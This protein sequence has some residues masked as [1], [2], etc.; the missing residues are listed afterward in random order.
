[1][2]AHHGRTPAV[3][4]RFFDRIEPVHAVT[5][6][7]PEARA[8][9]D[10]LG[11]RGF[12][13]GYFAARSAPLGVVP[14][15]VVTAAFYNFAPQRVAKALPT[16]WTVAPPA[17]ALEA[18]LDAAVAALLRAGVTDEDASAAAE[19]AAAAATHAEVGGRV[20]FAAN[21]ALEWPDRPVARLWHAATLLREH[22][23][24]GHV[25]VLLAEGVSGRE[26][27]VLHAAAGRV[28]AAMIQRSRDYDDDEWQRHVAALAE[29]GLLTADGT[30]TDAGH[31]LKEHLEGRTDASALTA[32]DVLSDDEL[33]QLFRALTPLTRTVIAAG[34]IPAGTPMG[35]R[36]DD[37][38]D[39]GAGL[40]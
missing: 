20:L 3:A 33:R 36:R 6:F 7:A 35:L 32:L 28:P 16:A 5:Y 27:N 40:D 9:L 4:R 19:L 14:T 12:W 13:M 10:A 18:R 39:D 15:D 21:R 25:A 2:P 38:D 24:D 30:L 23:G 26:S 29:R 31:R 11:Y 37:L 22:R 17:A 34:D 8:A 1:M